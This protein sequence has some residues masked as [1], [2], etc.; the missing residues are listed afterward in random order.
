MAALTLDD[1]KHELDELREVAPS[2]KPD[3]L[4][5]LWF[6]LAWLVDDPEEAHKTLVGGPHDRGI[7]AIHIDV[8]ARA[9]NLVQGKYLTGAT[10]TASRRD[11]DSFAEL[12]GSLTGDREQFDLLLEGADPLVKKRL[13]A[14]RKAVTKQDCRLSM[15]FVTSGRSPSGGDATAVKIARQGDAEFVLLNRRSVLRMLRDYL[16]GVAPPVPLVSLPLAEE[17]EISRSERSSAISAW[18][19]TA[20]GS[21]VANLYKRHG[22]RIFARNIRGY[23]GSDSTDVNKAIKGT[24]AKEADYFWYFNNGVTIACDDVQLVAGRKRRLDITNPQII[25]GQQTTRSLAEFAGSDSARVLVRV[26]ALPDHDIDLVS[27]IVE[28]TNHQNAIKA[29]DLMANDRRQVFL[30]RKLRARRYLYQRK[31]QSKREARASVGFRAWPAISKE[32]LAQ[33]VAACELDPWVARSAREKL[34]SEDRYD[35]VFPDK[36]VDYFLARYWFVKR[37]GGALRGRGTEMNYAKFFIAHSLW[38]EVGADIRRKQRDFIT[39]SEQPNQFH[40]HER[41]FEELARAQAAAVMSFFRSTREGLEVYAYFKRQGQ[42]KGFERGYGRLVPKTL[43]DRVTKK[44][45]AYQAA[46]KDL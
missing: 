46:L 29:S 24:L 38:K 3:E 5:V 13:I 1:L 4:F 10:A 32:E 43:R 28:A 36:S 11:I 41:A 20:K 8:G 19:C 39:A 22:T 23:L 12:A 9:V 35:D 40:K 25:N 37:V 31:R 30:E 42:F 2:A 16:D 45:K 14:A 18:V 7:D 27:K 21:D 17:G 6:V 26:V 33:A 34:F 44:K 15:Y